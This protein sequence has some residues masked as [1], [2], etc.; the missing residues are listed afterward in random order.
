VVAD[1]LGADSLQIVA[2]WRNPDQ[3]AKEGIRLY[4]QSMDSNWIVHT[5]DDNS[6]A[7]EDI[8]AADLDGDGKN[9]LIVSG[10]RSKNV[11]IYWNQSSI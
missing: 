3:L 9:D 8:T 6:M 1:F 4:Q 5:I 7:C 2:G 10:R 11:I